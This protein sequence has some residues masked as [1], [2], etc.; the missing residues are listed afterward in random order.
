MLESLV[1]LNSRNICKTM[2]QEHKCELKYNNYL[3]QVL[4]I[5]KCYG[6]VSISTP[7]LL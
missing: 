7:V 6:C 5:H 2:E 1:N 4:Y 3:L